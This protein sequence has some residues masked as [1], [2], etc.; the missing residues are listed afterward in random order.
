MEMLDIIITNGETERGFALIYSACYTELFPGL[1]ARGFDR[2]PLWPP[3]DFIYTALT[4]HFI[5]CPTIGK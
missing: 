2:T 4:V 1:W 5:K 3:K